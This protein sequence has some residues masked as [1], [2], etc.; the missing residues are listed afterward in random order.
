MP[1]QDIADVEISQRNGISI[2]WIIPLVALVIGGWMTAKAYLDQGPLV[3]IHFKSATG[4]VADKTKVRMRDVEIGVVESVVLSDDLEGAVVKVRLTKESE[5]MLVEGTRFWIESPRVTAG[6]IRGLQTLLSGVF[7][8]IDPARSGKYQDEFTGLEEPPFIGEEN[9]G[10]YYVLVSD[11]RYSI[12]VGSPVS[13]RGMDAGQVV[14]YKMND[15]G[16][17]V[18]TRIFIYKPYDKHINVNTR[19]WQSSGVNLSLGA[20]GL[21]V[22]T[23]SIVSIIS[24]GISFS[25]PGYLGNGELAPENHEFT[26]YGDQETAFEPEREKYPVLFYFSGSVRGLTIGAPVEFRGIKIGEVTSLHLQIDASDFSIKIPVV[27]EIEKGHFDIIKEGQYEEIT[28]ANQLE[29]M[30]RLVNNG[31]RAQLKTGS[32]I[33]GAIYIDFDIYKDSSPAVV[34][35]ENGVVVLP[36]IPTALDAITS[37]VTEILNKVAAMP[38]EQI[39]QDLGGAVK[40]TRALLESDQIDKAISNLNATLEETQQFARSF[41]TVITP[42]VESMLRELKNAS[43]SIKA[44]ADY[45]DRHPEA[46]IQG[47]QGGR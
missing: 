38:L 24:G 43:R 14:S 7:I 5:K 35:T 37:G 1:E 27:A 31:L 10:T 6:E 12:S 32:L 44:M 3:Q 11:R 23:E 15:E 28:N 4:V 26:V 25:T 22:E 33:T 34:T 13:Y 46:L 36:T 18:V 17:E 16:T 41:N 29:L 40:R 21:K 30:T 8:G 19:F 47:K 2:F 9:E 39:G 42:Q 45:L 20:D